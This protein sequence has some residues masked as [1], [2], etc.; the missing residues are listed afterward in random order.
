MTYIPGIEGLH[1]WTPAG[2]SEPA[3]TLGE[4]VYRII[5]IIG[6][7]S[8]GDTEENAD[9][10]VG[11]PGERQRPDQRR[12]KTVVYEGRIEA[13]TKK[14]MREAASALRA[15][16]ADRSAP[17]RMDLAVHPDDEELA[18][19]SP[20][21]LEAKVMNCDIPD[22]QATKRWSRKFVIG[23]R[24]GD[25]R[26]WEESGESGEASL[27]AT[28]E[29][30]GLEVTPALDTRAPVLDLALPA[31]VA[32][33][34]VTVTNT[35]T[36][37]SLTVNVPQGWDGKDLTLDWSRRTVTDSGGEDRSAWIDVTDDSL[38]ATPY[39]LI[40]GAKNELE[41]ATSRFAASGSPTN[42]SNDASIGNVA[43][44]NPGNAAAS[45]DTYATASLH[46]PSE[47]VSEYLV[48]KDLSALGLPGG[49]DV[50]GIEVKVEKG[51][52]YSYG[53]F[54]DEA[55][56]LVIGDEIQ[57]TD[58]ATEGAWL[59]AD[60]VVTY[61]GPEDLW[62]AESLK[63]SDIGAGLGFAFSAWFRVTSATRRVADIDRIGPIIIYYEGAFDATATFRWE[64]GYY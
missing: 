36:G 33:I 3:L 10:L 24:A 63:G 48:A 20:K 49:A 39:P 35:T 44:E 1:S 43:W 40:A 53:L 2:A 54:E 30:V 5:G 12:G 13:E 27:E 46:Y 28:D 8:L 37:K 60:T 56:R 29:E 59:Q 25:P 7:E 34:G 17:G 9:A 15:A 52:P 47:T 18:G 16:F 50:K 45:D 38:W 51:S 32:A 22:Q 55:A 64:R 41:I 11:A 58:R 21:F 6:L 19:V 57:A 31:T 26:V 62:G 42:F 4:G 23:L 61:G 14:E